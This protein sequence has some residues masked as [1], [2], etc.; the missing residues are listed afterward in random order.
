[1][2][3]VKSTTTIPELPP[4]I[5][6]I[7]PTLGD[8]SP[9][10][11]RRFAER[12]VEGTYSRLGPEL[13]GNESEAVEYARMALRDSLGKIQP[14]SKLLS[15]IYPTITKKEEIQGY[16]NGI[17]RLLKEK[18]LL[19]IRKDGKIAS[20]IGIV[21]GRTKWP[22]GR[23]CY[24]IGKITTL[25]EYEGRGFYKILFNEAQ[26]IVKEENQDSPII[27]V[28][29]NPIIINSVKKS[30]WSEIPFDYGLN[31]PTVNKESLDYKV[32]TDYRELINNFDPLYAKKWIRDGISIFY[33]D[34]K[35][36]KS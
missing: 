23:D 14:Q 29:K 24:E 6:I 32:A 8:F 28:T 16:I 22:D 17:K 18:R 3:E 19:A 30:G 34:P 15:K 2:T 31:D 27:T 9:E 35:I 4:G 10:L 20:I 7:Q 26:K 12:L 36:M 5:E 25:P 13:G 11:I 21:N 1:M 33:F